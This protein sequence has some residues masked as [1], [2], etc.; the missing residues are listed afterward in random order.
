MTPEHENTRGASARGLFVEP[1][2]LRGL[3]ETVV[4]EVLEAEVAEYLHAA[5]YERTAQRRGRRNGSKPRGMKTALG[6]LELQLPQVREGGFRTQVFERWQ[7]SDKALVAALQEMVVKGV[8]T[9][10]V[11][12]VLEKLGGFEVSAASVSHA[13]AQL[14]EQITAFFERD[15]SGTNYP[16]LIIDA[17]Y[18]KVRRA[19][20]VRSQAVLIVAGVREDGHRE[21]LALSLGD[22]ESEATWGE[23]FASLKRRKLRGVQLIVSD[24]HQGIR[25]AMS[26]H[27]QGVAWQRCRVHLM[28][29]MLGKVSW[30]ERKELA[31]DV[32]AIYASEE[33]EQ[34]RAVGEEIAAKWDRRAPRMSRALRAGL[35]DTLAVWTLPAHLR[36]RLNST[37]M[38][39]RVMKEIKRRTRSV[40]AFP[41]EKSCWRL[42]GAVLLEMQDRWDM[43][44][45]RYLILDEEAM[46]PPVTSP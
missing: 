40:G 7:R 23:I 21:L 27:F 39:E 18:E 41:N 25:A 13:M 14:D 10:G 9:R 22:S 6:L 2:L 24:A 15:L 5:P 8:S 45:A 19:G 12:A 33:A 38:L 29:E 31:A 17:R 34:C 11:S 36:R 20:R 4:Q 26:R 42:V 46:V 44:P 1:D 30:R 37:N 32:R 3:V 43:E 16:Y 28:R 35:D